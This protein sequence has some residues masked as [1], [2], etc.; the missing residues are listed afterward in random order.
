VKIAAVASSGY[1]RSTPSQSHKGAAG[2]A[3]TPSAGKIANA[4]ATTTPSSAVGRTHA[5]PVHGATPK[6]HNKE[7]SGAHK[8]APP[9][10][11]S[12][13]AAAAGLH[14]AGKMTIIGGAAKKGLTASSKAK[15]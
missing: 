8:G 3:T 9:S 12:K 13:V 15:E 7:V 14:H 2:I 5:T 6:T 10:G 11:S 4:A 1:G